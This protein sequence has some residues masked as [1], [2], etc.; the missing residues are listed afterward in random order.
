MKFFST[1]KRLYQSSPTAR[2]LTFI[3]FIGILASVTSLSGK[4]K[5]GKPQISS[6]NPPIAS[7]GDIVVIEGKNFGSTRD[8]SFVEIAGSRVTASGYRDWDDKTIEFTVPSNVQD[9]LVVVQTASGRSEPTF[10]AKEDSIPVAVRTDF[11]A[12][13]PLIESISPTTARI[14]DTISIHGSNFGNLRGNSTVY[15]SANRDESATKVPSEENGFNPKFISASES[16]YDFEYWTDSEIRVH[17]PDG[18]TSGQIYVATDKGNSYKQN[19]DITYPA[20]QK[21]LTDARTYVLQI[22][23]DIQ[24]RGLETSTVT[25]YVPR[26]SVSVSQP[27]VVLNEVSPT[28]LIQDDPYDV[29]HSIQMSPTENPRVRVNQ[30][31]VVTSFSQQSQIKGEKITNSHESSRLMYTVYTAPDQ[32]VPSDNQAV[33]DLAETIVGKN[34]NPYIRSQL[35]YNY[36]IDNFK[37]INTVRTGDVSPLDLIEKKSGDAYDFAIIFTALCRAMNIPAVPVSGILVESNSTTKNHWWTEIYF[38]HYGW[39]PVD[40]SLAAGLPYKGFSEIKNPV[41][42]YFGN[43]DGQHIAFS[44]KWNNLKTSM[45]SSK[46][47]FRPRSYAL[48]SIWEEVNSTEGNY[49]S[50]WNDPVVVGIYGLVSY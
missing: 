33:I 9:G 47:I 22:S 29:I 15:F 23:A 24:N 27:A 38:E 28:P 48:Q 5:I 37:I 14:G 44:R 34:K 42:Y 49:S 31:F 40:V 13:V 3:I 18:A 36:M 2:I 30:N 8:S 43:L 46:T 45:D 10:F 12:A 6:I 16:D 11:R 20:G 7:P 32:C 1:I 35:I 4:K 41:E 21:L 26:P 17:V 50:L 39:F 25:L 19:L